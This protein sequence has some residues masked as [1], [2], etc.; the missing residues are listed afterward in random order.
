MQELN[1]SY[2]IKYLKY[3]KKYFSLKNSNLVDNTGGSSYIDL[4]STK[5]LPGPK[6]LNLSGTNIISYI[7]I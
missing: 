2:K 1:T 4:E 3:K 5:S 6:Y 7:N